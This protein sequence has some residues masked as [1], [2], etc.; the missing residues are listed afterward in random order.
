MDKK[1]SLEAHYAAQKEQMAKN[2]DQAI[3]GLERLKAEKLEVLEKSEKAVLEEFNEIGKEVIQNV[4]D[5]SN[6]K[7][8][9][10]QNI[11]KIIKKIDLEDFL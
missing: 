6:I 11:E 5:M 4:A 1:S 9:I 7:S 2:I 3:A 10:S 8:D